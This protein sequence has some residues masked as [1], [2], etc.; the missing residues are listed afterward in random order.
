MTSAREILDSMNGFEE[1]AI[2]KATGKSLEFWSQ[3]DRDIV[4]HRIAVAVD[5]CRADDDGKTPLD[6]RMKAAWEAT[7]AMTQIAVR[8]HFAEDE[9]EEA[10]PDEPVTELGKDDSL[11]EPELM[12]SPGSVS[13][14]V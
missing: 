5:R 8:D 12:T 13:Q 2:E 9:D 14:P 1:L 10:F 11:S 3:T 4:V 7:Q 6:R